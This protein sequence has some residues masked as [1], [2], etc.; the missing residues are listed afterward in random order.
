M[1]C[2]QCG[3]CCGIVPITEEEKDTI[4]KY[5]KKNN[6]QPR[7]TILELSSITCKFLDNDNKCMIYDV[8]PRICR[9]F[10][11]NVEFDKLEWPSLNCSTFLNNI[12]I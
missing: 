5:C 10:Y 1:D 6:V 7:N 4:I 3:K 8:R 9:N 2:K 11:C 12:K